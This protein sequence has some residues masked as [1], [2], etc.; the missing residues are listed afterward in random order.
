[1]WSGGPPNI[2]RSN[3]NGYKGADLAYIR[4][5]AIFQNQQPPGWS[6]DGDFK[7]PRPTPHGALPKNIAHYR[8]LYRQKDGIILSYAAGSAAVLDLPFVTVPDKAPL[9]CRYLHVQNMQ[10]PMSMFLAELPGGSAKIQGNV[11]V[12]Q[13]DNVVIAVGANYQA[14]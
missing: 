2:S 3:L 11:A 4:L 13:R 12:L 8:G 6:L 14:F 1:A 10:E 9:F 5:P 7:D